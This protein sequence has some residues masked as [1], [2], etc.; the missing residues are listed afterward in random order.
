MCVLNGRIDPLSENFTSASPKGKEVVDYIVT[1]LECL[2]NCVEFKVLLSS[3][4]VEEKALFNL[5]DDHYRQP[6]HSL[7][8][9]KFRVSYKMPSLKKCL[10][11]LNT[12][13]CG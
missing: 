8:W 4:I 3:Q 13:K 10:L 9:L 5:I 2:E 1:P 12:L 11:Q 6:D 7:L